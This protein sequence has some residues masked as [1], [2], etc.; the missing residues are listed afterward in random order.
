VAGRPTPEGLVKLGSFEEW[1]EIVGGIL[2]FSGIEGFLSTWADD[3]EASDTETPQWAAFLSELLKVTTGNANS[4]AQM[5]ALM[6]GEP[7]HGVPG[8]RELVEALPDD[9]AGAFR[10]QHRSFT[11]V[12]G[13]AFSSVKGRRF[14]EAGLR[15]VTSGEQ[16]KVARWRVTD[17]QNE[18][19]R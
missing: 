11:R 12:L 16:H 2:A 6:R 18:G 4:T 13:K 1:C 17:D 5:E 10:D 8:A 7:E 9:L 15:I 19:N 3:R 14:S